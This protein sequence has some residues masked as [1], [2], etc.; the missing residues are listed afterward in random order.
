MGQ[1]HTV[2]LHYSYKRRE[3]HAKE[4]QATEHH[5]SGMEVFDLRVHPVA[6]SYDVFLC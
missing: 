2:L 4:L 6:K 5:K 3:L 1:D